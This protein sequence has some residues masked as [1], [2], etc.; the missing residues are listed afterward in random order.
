VTH[1]NGGRSD[2]CF[3]DPNSSQIAQMLERYLGERPFLNASNGFLVTGEV[4][5]LFRKE[6]RQAYGLKVEAP[7]RVELALC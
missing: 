7:Q 4:I 6:Q 1:P 3:L 2:L 5:F